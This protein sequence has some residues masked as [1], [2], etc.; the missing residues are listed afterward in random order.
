MTIKEGISVSEG[1][2]NKKPVVV[3]G[4][5]FIQRGDLDIITHNASV[6]GKAQQS[7]EK[8]PGPDDGDKLD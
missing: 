2:S 7:S 8:K 3:N 4:A 1:N 6:K 5:D